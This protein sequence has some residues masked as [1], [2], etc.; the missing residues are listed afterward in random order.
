MGILKNSLRFFS[1]PTLVQ[2][3]YSNDCGIA[4]LKMV[5]NF[6]N[7][8]IRLSTIRVLADIDQEGMSIYDLVELSKSLGLEGF[9]AEMSFDDL[10]EHH[11]DIPLPCILHWRENHFV[12]LSSIGKNGFSILDPALGKLKLSPSE[13]AEHWLDQNGKGRMLLLSKSGKPEFES[14][15]VL[16]DNQSSFNLLKETVKHLMPHRKLIIRAVWSMFFIL[17][18]QLLLPFLMQSFIDAGI[19]DQN[20]NAA[21]LVMGAFIVFSASTIILQ[22]FQNWMLLFIGARLRVGMLYDFISSIAKL[23]SRFF[24]RNFPADLM[25]RFGDHARIEAFV[26]DLSLKGVLVAISLLTFGLLL[27]VYH[28]GL[29]FLFLFFSVLS[30]SIIIAYLPKR[31]MLDNQSFNLASEEQEL[32]WEYVSHV[33]TVRM[34][35]YTDKLRL[36]WMRFQEKDLDLDKS[37]LKLAMFQE[38]G[39]SLVNLLRDTL[40]SLFSAYLVINGEMTLGSLIAVQFIVAQL[41]VSFQYVPALISTTQDAVLS[42]ERIEHVSIFEKRDTAKETVERFN[43]LVVGDLNFTYKRNE[44]WQLRAI[45]L[46]LSKGSF[47]AIVGPSGCG[48]TSLLKILA[49]K[50]YAYEG[51]VLVNNTVELNAINTQHYWEI[52]AY[53]QADDPVF[54]LSILEN[55]IMGNTLDLGWLKVCLET[56]EMLA[57]VN[58][59]SKGLHTKLGE[60]GINLSLGQQ[61]RILLARLMYSKPQLVFIDEIPNA[62][63]EAQSVRIIKRIRVQLEHLTIVLCTHTRSLVYAADI[64]VLMH[65]GAIVD[66]GPAKELE[67]DSLAFRSLFVE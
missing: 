20:F 17:F 49:K 52:S 31:K 54:S 19:E 33:D 45:N 4:C 15:S 50:Y 30:T 65:E 48:K 24:D 47:T 42:A 3:V 36:N 8:N 59:L 26:R 66:Q 61:Q 16:Q 57:F 34:N 39:A 43:G 21:L 41:N 9:P 55:V 11:A 60:Q 62:L 32:L 38:G 28:L 53:A 13:F 18:L 64:A 29:M 56:V 7:I 6:H 27:S 2:Q 1:Q 14:K 35:G 63:S 25:Q 12:V 67:S 23:P 44:D 37:Q 10:K 22:W 5:A 46:E 51:S 40:V 58:K